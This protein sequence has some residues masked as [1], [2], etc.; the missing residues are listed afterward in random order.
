[1][2]HSTYNWKILDKG[3]NFAPNLTLIGGLNKK[4]QA[5]KVAGVP[6]SRIS[7]LSTWE[8]QDKM[9]F[10]CRPPGQALRII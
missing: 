2:W 5:S 6:I 4:L 8:S 9:T 10:G 1:M 3:Y 7:G